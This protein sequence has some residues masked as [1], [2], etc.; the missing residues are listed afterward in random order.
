MSTTGRSG[1]RSRVP[2]V[3]SAL[4]LLAWLASGSAFAAGG[5][6]ADLE[7][8]DTRAA[9]LGTRA[10]KIELETRPGTFLS[11][12]EAI[13]R[14]QDNLFLHMIGEHAPAAEG[15]FALVTSA[16]LKDAGLH[17]DAEWYLGEALIGLGNFKTA[18]SRFQ[19]IVEDGGHPFREDAVRRLLEIYAQSGDKEAFQDLYQRE[20]ESGRVAPTGLILYSLAKSFYQQGD[21]EEAWNYFDQV[22][23]TSVWYG[24]SRYFLGV[25]AVQ[26]NRL[27]DA[28][29]EFTTVT[30]LSIQTTEDRLVHDLGLLALGRVHYH[31]GDFTQAAEFY[32]R[33]GGDSRYQADKL[34]EVIWTSIRRERWRDALNNV[35]IFLLAF[36]EHQYAAQ[37]RLL[38]G[39]LNFQERSWDGALGSYEQV[40]TD[41]TPVQARFA[42]LASGGPGAELAVREVLE[43]ET[44]TDDLPPFAVAMMRADP[45]LGRAMDVFR[46]LQSQQ[47]DIEISERLITEIRPFIEGESAVGSFERARADAIDAKVDVTDAR[48]DLLEVEERWLTGLSDAEV[49]SR[50]PPLSER[51]KAAAARLEALSQSIDR[52]TAAVEAFD[53]QLSEVANRA[54]DARR[55]AAAREADLTRLRADLAEGTALDSASRDR[56]TAEIQ[57]LEVQLGEAR[58]RA[59]EAEQQV[60]SLAPP[61]PV[62]GATQAELGAVYTEVAL[63]TTEF[64]GARPGRTGL[65]A[66]D[67]MDA[68]HRALDDAWTRLGFATE[69]LNRTESAEVG[70]IRARFEEEVQNVAVERADYEATLVAAREVSVGLTRDGFGRL[71]DFFAESVLKA[72]MG[73]VDVYWAQKLDVADELERVKEEK[74]LLVADLERRF[75]L[76]RAKMGEP[77]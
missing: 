44:G 20:I 58:A 11:D 29:T 34:Y 46:G 60:A 43:A 38:Q 75:A 39:H 32:N 21:S 50:L 70:K 3:R 13:T 66:G 19:L 7:Q 15:F 31:L 33:I 26:D 40:I 62:D 22:P 59:Q 77:R 69:S 48:L 30:G 61:P 1:P 10:A 52:S 51:R 54:E 56:M 8:L 63:L 67:R 16:A 37:L 41:Y 42:E 12:E 74:E 4:A 53:L 14:F 35:E 45:A 68:A 27:E 71:E 6:E 76:I 17:R 28:I 9:E 47:R 55:E 36:P 73:I 23:A 49:A 64:Y 18:A 5:V 57:Q 65:V 24:R 2:R 72:D 25:I